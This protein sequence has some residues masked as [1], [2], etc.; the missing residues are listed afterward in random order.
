MLN[1]AEY[2]LNRVPSKSVNSTPYEIWCEKKPSLSYLRI[3]GY[4]VYVKHNESDK[5]EARSDKYNFMRYPKETK[6]YFFYN[7]LE[8]KMFVL[9][10]ATFLENDILSGRDSER[11]I[12]LRK[13]QKP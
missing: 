3:W 9:R 4:Y 2:I 10:H 8:Q 11:R 12:E 6:E 5:P 13:A 7:P 1:T